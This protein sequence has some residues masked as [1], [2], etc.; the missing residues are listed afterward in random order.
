MRIADDT[1]GRG[2][3]PSD[4]GA[5]ATTAQRGSFGSEQ[6]PA[7]PAGQNVLQ[8]SPAGNPHSA[9]GF[10]RALMRTARK[11][12]SLKDQLPDKTTFSGKDFAKPSSFAQGGRRHGM[13]IGSGAPFA[14]P[15]SDAGEDF[16]NQ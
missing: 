7:A 9:A 3:S 13:H 1:G 14:Q 10:R 6:N 12:S 5:S 11:G 8:N 4:F 15:A 2:G 16:G